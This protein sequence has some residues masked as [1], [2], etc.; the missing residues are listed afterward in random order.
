MQAKRRLATLRACQPYNLKNL[1]RDAVRLYRN[2]LR[3]ESYDGW[4]QGSLFRDRSCSFV[5]NGLVL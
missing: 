1:N 3:A 2:R 5:A 4:G